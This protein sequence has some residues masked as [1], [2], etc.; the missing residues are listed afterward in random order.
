MAAIF[1]VEDGSV[2]TDANALVSVADADQIMENYDN[3]TAWSGASQAEKE[4][5]IR[6]ATRFLNLNYIWDGYKVDADQT[7]QWPRYE[8][9]DEDGW[10]IDHEIVPERVKEAC[11]YLALKVMEGD[12][13]LEDL[14]N[15]SRVKK[16]KDVIG[17][18]TEEREYIG[19]ESP[20]K[21]Y[22]VVEKLISPFII[23]GEGF[24]STEIERG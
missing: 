16:T 12:T 6:L 9:Y 3:P 4:N 14:Q 18:L 17:P 15:E 20:E 19:G 2:V 7:C 13:L 22:K 10:V 11:A 24:S 21:T 8:T 1:T 23:N 5:A